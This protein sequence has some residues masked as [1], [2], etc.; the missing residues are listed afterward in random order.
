M[1]NCHNIQ[2]QILLPCST[3]MHK[4][5]YAYNKDKL[6]PKPKPTIQRMNIPSESLQRLDRILSSPTISP[7]RKDKLVKE[8]A[9]YCSVCGAVATQIAN[10][11]M[12]DATLV[13]KYC[14]T[15]LARGI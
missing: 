14:D 8:I 2:I 3:K 11:K 1:N 10:Y 15:C 12:V 6:T 9:G 5:Y 4:F 7:Y 13:E